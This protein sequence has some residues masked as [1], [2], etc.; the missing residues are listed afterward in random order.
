MV[1]RVAAGREFSAGTRQ[2][3]P[4]ELGLLAW[5]S[6]S[7]MSEEAWVGSMTNLRHRSSHLRSFL[8]SVKLLLDR[9]LNL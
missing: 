4:G 7:Y 3:A 1:G 5:C 9:Q 6:G 8:H 2:P